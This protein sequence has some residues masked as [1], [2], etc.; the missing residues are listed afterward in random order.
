MRIRVASMFL[1]DVE[2]PELY[3]AE[4]LLSFEKSDKGQWL[5]KHSYRD[6]EYSIIPDHEKMGFIVGVFAW[7]DE[8]EMLLYKLKWS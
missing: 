4:P 8:K 1:G 2:D 5:K 7:L 3:A 6:M